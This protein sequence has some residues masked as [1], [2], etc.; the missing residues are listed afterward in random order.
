MSSST[1]VPNAWPLR[2]ISDSEVAVFLHVSE[3]EA[4]KRRP[5]LAKQLADPVWV[6]QTLDALPAASLAA[7]GLVLE[8][9]GQRA[10][11]VL[12]RLVHERFG[13]SRVDFE[14]AMREAVQ[15]LLV[16]PLRT[17]WGELRLA[18][19][20][21]AAA[22]IAPLLAGLDLL[23][24]SSA[25]FAPAESTTRN[26]RIFVALCAAVPHHEIR[27]TSVGDIHRGSIKRLARQVG[28]DE[29]SVAALLE[30]GLHVG[31]LLRQGEG[32]RLDLAMLAEA[33]KGR[34]PRYAPLGVLAAQL[35]DAVVASEA[36]ARLLERSLTAQH[37]SLA[38][39]TLGHLPGFVTGTAN[40][41]AACTWRP[42]GG[43]AAGHV[44]P[45]FEV[46]LPPESPLLDVAHVGACSEWERL[47][48][49]FVARITKPSIARAVAAGARAEQILAWL[50]A[51]SRHPIPQNVEAAIRDWAGTMV[52]ATIATGHVIVVEPGAAPRAAAALSRL[53]AR[54]I[55]PGVFV[56]DGDERMREITGALGRAGIHHRGTSGD[57]GSADAALREATAANAPA[58]AVPAPLPAAMRLRARVAAW[59]RGEPFEGVRDDFLDKAR[60]AQPAVPIAAPSPTPQG[61]LERWATEH[62]PRLLRDPAMFG[63]IMSL[64]RLFSAS[65]LESLLD[66]CDTF[67]DLVTGLAMASVKRT[68]PV[69]SAQPSE[70][71]RRS[72]IAST[73][74]PPTIPVRR[75]ALLWQRE[76]LRERLQRA[77][78]R[79]DA[80]ALQLADRVRYVEISQVIRR[81]TI[82]MVLGED[83]AIDVD[84][85]LRLDEI[86]A[87]AALPDD[88]EIES[89]TADDDDLDDDDLDGQSTPRKPWRPAPGQTAPAGHRPCPCGSGVRYRNCC[90]EVVTA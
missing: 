40:G 30:T 35:G 72:T 57:D 46:F 36:A 20:E 89:I 62:Y 18:V 82:W 10:E 80:L 56:V 38:G 90:R 6:A 23:A 31:V 34:Y 69:S 5:I 16:I 76:E 8:G 86:Q 75:P 29:V 26:P 67:S 43:T 85:A 48:R 55:A 42:P 22:L 11:A 39:D 37:T 77:A 2:S 27:L 78:R 52:S 33:A 70:A 79:G 17:S 4:R 13:M 61:G 83:L 49:A 1:E 24:L 64:A 88:F 65:E 3:K 54:E 28:V 53:A 15:R 73:R 19:V 32:V 87:I 14:A 25:D 9:G 7:L 41:V 59:R 45:S 44:T 50:A 58:A 71:V 63:R 84:V 60:A 21:P 66:E 47:D 81:G 12:V 51:A 74:S 68:R